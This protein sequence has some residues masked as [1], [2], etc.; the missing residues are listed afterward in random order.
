MHRKHVRTFRNN[1]SNKKTGGG[2]PLR[3]VCQ[4]SAKPVI[5]GV[6]NLL[7]ISPQMTFA[8]PKR[9]HNGPIK[10]SVTGGPL[11][12]STGQRPAFPQLV[13]T[14]ER[15]SEWQYDDDDEEAGFDN[16]VDEEYASD[17]Q[18][19][20]KINA[21]YWHDETAG[22]QGRDE[23]YQ[24]EVEGKE[25]QDEE[26]EAEED[27][28]DWEVEPQTEAIAYLFSV[29]NEAENL[30]AM[31]Y[32]TPQPTINGIPGTIPSKPPQS[33]NSLPAFMQAQENPWESRFL[34]YYRSLRHS[35]AS[36]PEPLLSQPELD[37]LLH[38]NPNSR[39]TTSSQEDTLWR[40]K[41]LDP[42]SL[43]LLAMLD[44]QRI[45]HL[46]THLR[47]KMSA[48]TKREQ[49]MWLVFLLASLGDLGVLNGNEVDLLRR[50]GRKCLGVRAGAEDEVVLSTIDMV[51]CIIR[52]FYEQRD[53][54]DAF[55]EQTA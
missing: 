36:H 11:N 8:M 33:S 41:T 47:K 22:D 20:V 19:D 48:N 27:Y 35:I 31:T 39:P 29:R 17:M 44:H 5:V 2:F 46:L 16:D 30:P 50:I 6:Q 3:L 21:G 45:I 53:L 4:R 24:Y 14:H 51:V 12:E 52:W 28:E 1:T 10:P 32:I 15:D 34:E 26:S 25:D 13:S 9:K 54:E 40:L 42:P 7:E 38:I 55:P 43:D 49:C 18:R 23:E 37:V